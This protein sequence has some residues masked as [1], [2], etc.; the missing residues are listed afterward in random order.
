MAASPVTA[1][2]NFAI[3]EVA[4]FGADDLIV[5]VALAGDQHGIARLAE[6][7]APARSRA[8]D[9]ARSARAAGAA[10]PLTMSAT[11]ASPSSV[12]GL[13][14]VTI[15]TI[16]E[17]LGDRAHQRTLARIAIAAAA[18]HADQLARAVPARGEQRLLQRVRRM[19][20]VDDR[21]RLAGAVSV[22]MRPGGA[23]HCSSAAT[24]SCER[25]VPAEQH[26]QRREQ[27]LDVEVADEA[28]AQRRDAPAAVD[29]RFRDHAAPRRARAANRCDV[30]AAVIGRPT[31]TACDVRASG[32]Q[33]PLQ[34]SSSVRPNASSDIDDRMLAAPA[35]R[36][37]CAFAAAVASNVP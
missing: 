15:T 35:T 22:S 9:R 20:V 2:R 37:A 21:E 33:C 14:S 23:A 4:A 16:G 3:A 28:R 26:G 7:D 13:S 34:C 29:D 12:R 10:R 1:L 18:E 32:L 8:R 27:I 25:H 5:L 24:A 6:R 11:I 31:T 30:A 19:R 36:T 17:P